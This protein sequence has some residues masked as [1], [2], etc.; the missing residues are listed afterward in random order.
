MAE[1]KNIGSYAVLAVRD[2]VVFPGTVVP[3]FVGREMSVNAIEQV[4]NNSA[5]ELLCLA[6][7]DAEKEDVS[8]KDLY[9]YGTSMRIL[10]AVNMPDGTMKLLAEGVARVRVSRLTFDK[11]SRVFK[12]RG[13]VFSTIDQV[14]EELK[15][16]SRVMQEK[17]SE[18]V[19]A[20]EH[21][22]LDLIANLANISSVEEYTDLISSH[23]PI[24]VRS[25]QKI[26]ETADLGARIKLVLGLIESERAWKDKEKEVLDKV[27][28]EIS[29]EQKSY[30]LRKKLEVMQN[31]LHALDGDAGLV[32]DLPDFEDKARRVKLSAETRKK[33]MNEVGKLKLMPSMS[34][35]AA[36]IRNYLDT[37]FS[38]SWGKYDPI[39]Q[40]LDAAMDILNKDHYGLDKIKERIIESL[41]VSHRVSEIK[42][43]ILCF[44]GPPGVG[45]TSLGQSI[46]KAMGRSFVRVALGGVREDSEIRGHRRTFVGAMPGQII[47]A[48]GRTSTMN[49]LIMLDEIDKMGMDF[50]GDPASALLEVLDPEQNDKFADHYIE[51][52][53]D[54]SKVLFITTANTTDIPPALLDRM[55]L[56]HLS[57]YTAEEKLGI[58]K[59]Y[60]VAK[61]MKNNG[62]SSKELA[63]DDEA[64]TSVISDY[65]GEAGVRDL[66]RCLSKICRKVV[67]E[68]HG[69]RAASKPKVIKKSHLQKYLQAPHYD[70]HS[71]GK[72]PAVGVVNGLAWTCVGGELLT[73]EALKLPGKGELVYTG[74]LG[75]VMQE[76]IK[77]AYSVVR[78]VAKKY[79]FKSSLLDKHDFHIHVP[80]G[81]T[82]KDGPSAGIGMATALLSVITGHK[83]ANDVAMTG[84]ITLRGNVIAIG[85]LKEKILAA[86]RAGA[87]TVILP[88]QNQKDLKDFEKD[89]KGKVEIVFVSHI[90]E[91]FKKVLVK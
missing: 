66:E 13:E 77:A 51:F 69:K 44:V 60:L 5:V 15:T 59:D 28:D 46:A 32:G 55:E 3:L 84:E 10:Q 38:V 23:L 58:A 71:I 62:L 27:R 31:E 40:D 4:I 72:K 26:L 75:E 16:L 90:D 39:N 8:V 34:S 91:V 19:Q 45:K 17:F 85:G 24:S 81:A 36:V 18:Y 9:R 56:I 76:S 1:G 88:K 70:K 12:A 2:I 89:I 53:A 73:I 50:R 49:P 11:A 86:I 30:F 63:F 7:R 35:E 54:L 33:L 80:E 78:S 68:R 43:P 25:K 48:L 20:T 64:L 67:R 42:A 47:R 65:T 87:K 52:E 29:K 14:S 41:A 74:S 21:L 61:T 22:S 79:Q 6:Q 82:P 37:V 83:V 57:G